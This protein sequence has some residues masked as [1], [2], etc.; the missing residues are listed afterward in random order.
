M[1]TISPLTRAMVEKSK[2]NN[3]QTQTQVQAQTP[4]PEIKSDTVELSTKNKTGLIDKIKANK[5][6]IIPAAIGLAA[7]AGG[8]IFAIK[9]GKISFKGKIEQQA[10]EILGESEK[11]LK[12]S[13]EIKIEYVD[14][15]E[16]YVKKGIQALVLNFLRY[17]RPS[18]YKVSVFDYIHYNADVLGPLSVLTSGK[19]SIIEK[20]A[21]DSKSLRQNIAILADYYRKVESKVGTMT[22][23]QYNK[24]QKPEN[25]IQTV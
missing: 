15:N 14:R 25:R 19:N 7:I 10:A 11:I 2:L 24:Q 16:A 18:E 9:T 4:A 8:L 22:L 17:F 13:E 20:P 6:I 1:T 3:N 23:S 5:K 12:N 21:S